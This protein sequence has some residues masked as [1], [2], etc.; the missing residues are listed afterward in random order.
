MLLKTFFEVVAMMYFWVSSDSKENEMHTFNQGGWHHV[1]SSNCFGETL[2]SLSHPFS[3]CAVG[4]TG[5]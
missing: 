2:P 1:L 4:E 3:Q 5:Y